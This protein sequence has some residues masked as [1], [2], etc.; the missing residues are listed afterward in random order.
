[1]KN[2]LFFAC[3]LAPSLAFADRLGSLRSN[4]EVMLSTQGI[5][6]R[7]TLQAGATFYVSSGTVAGQFSAEVVKFE[8]AT[9][10]TTILNEGEMS[11]SNQGS[12]AA[13]WVWIGGNRY[14]FSLTEDNASNQF[15]LLEDNSFLLLEDNSKM[16][17]E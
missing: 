11:V 10:S 7:D 16:V 6:N 14:R 9:T 1:M 12:V 3:F 2:L 5:Y 4:V 8:V 17:I 15:I 13:A